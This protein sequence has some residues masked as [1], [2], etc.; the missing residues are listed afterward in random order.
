M[1]A[2]EMCHLQNTKTPRNATTF[3]RSK[4]TSYHFTAN[5]WYIT[6]SFL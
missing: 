5:L 1:M 2:S 6:D 3:M 4:K